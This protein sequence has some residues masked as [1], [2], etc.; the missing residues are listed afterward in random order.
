MKSIK[1]I[2]EGNDGL[3]AI[4][5]DD[6]DRVYELIQDFIDAGIFIRSFCFY[7]PFSEGFTNDIKNVVKN[8][9]KH[10]ILDFN[11]FLSKNIIEEIKRT[12]SIAKDV[13]IQIVVVVKLRKNRNK[14]INQELTYC[15]SKEDLFTELDNILK[16]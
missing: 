10:L 11:I 9:E 1:K 15:V 14:V 16:I 6:K 8:G 5:S 7:Q 2:L 13:G 3:L 4:T 12:I